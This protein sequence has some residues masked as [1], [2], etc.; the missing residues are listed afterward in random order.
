MD[1]F[2]QLYFVICGRDNYLYKR[3]GV[4]KMYEMQEGGGVGTCDFLNA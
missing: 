1:D 4:H 2:S 3:M